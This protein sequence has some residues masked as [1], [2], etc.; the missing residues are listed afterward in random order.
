[1]INGSQS[2][3]PMEGHLT[4]MEITGSSKL[5]ELRHTCLPFQQHL[6][7]LI[8]CSRASLSSGIMI[9]ISHVVHCGVKGG[10]T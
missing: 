3:Q 6:S 8:P 1:M 7:M 5:Q 9:V 2:H 10:D 4:D